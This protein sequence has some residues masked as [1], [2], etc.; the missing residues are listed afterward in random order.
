MKTKQKN[1]FVASLAAPGRWKV[2][3]LGTKKRGAGVIAKKNVEKES[4]REG[5]KEENPSMLKTPP[6]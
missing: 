1:G 4:Q 3:V 6:L 2:R 5:G